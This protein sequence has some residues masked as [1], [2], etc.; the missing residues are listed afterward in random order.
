MIAA[1]AAA[2]QA[3]DATPDTANTALD[4]LKAATDQVATVQASVGARGR[5]RR[6]ARRRP[7]DRCDRPRGDARKR[8]TATDDTAAITELQKT[9]TILSATQASFAKLSQLVAVR[10]SALIP[11]RR[12][13]PG[14]GKAN[15]DRQDF[16]AVPKSCRIAN[17]GNGLAT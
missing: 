14:S 15:E 16:A 10:L 8:S 3:G 1:L 7:Q 12:H 11:V 5:A 9:M 6:S 4:D 2:L 17:I 13:P